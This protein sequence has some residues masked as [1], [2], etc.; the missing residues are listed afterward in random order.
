MEEHAHADLKWF[1]DQW[2]RR[3][4]SPEIEGTWSYDAGSKKVRIEL[5]QAQPGD[6]YRLPLE[7]GLDTGVAGPERIEKIELHERHQSFEIASGEGPSSVVLDPHTWVLM[8]AHL[9]KR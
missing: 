6:A 4:G 7:V 8:K 2:L 1:F 3:P 9:V 5:T